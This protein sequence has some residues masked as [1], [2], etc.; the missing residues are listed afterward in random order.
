VKYTINRDSNF[1]EFEIIELSLKNEKET[2]EIYLNGKHMRIKK[3]NFFMFLIKNFLF[4][5]VIF[6]SI[7]LAFLY[8][9]PLIAFFYILFAVFVYLIIDSW[10]KVKYI[11]R[12]IFIMY[13]LHAAIFFLTKDN[14]GFFGNVEMGSYL[15][16]GSF[17]FHLLLI[18]MRMKNSYAEI[19]SIQEEISTGNWYLWASNLCEENE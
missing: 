12:I 9:Y 15:V 2:Q 8:F 1:T 10:C 11:E 7:V 19:Y 3:I 4:F 16:F 18:V 17:V 6:V 14:G 13:L 5:A